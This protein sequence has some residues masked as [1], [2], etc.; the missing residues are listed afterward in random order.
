MG[1]LIKR[2]KPLA[3]SSTDI[4]HKYLVA[5]I[6]YCMFQDITCK[7]SHIMFYMWFKNTS[8]SPNHTN[9]YNLLW[10]SQ[11]FDRFMTLHALLGCFTRNPFALKIINQ[12]HEGYV[13]PGKTSE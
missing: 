4:E 6:L 3:A 13:G 7:S 8:S 10:Y 12:K 11:R 1:K 2:L 5:P 9:K